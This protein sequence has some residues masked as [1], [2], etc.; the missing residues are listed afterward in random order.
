MIT[1]TIFFHNCAL[2]KTGASAP[3]QSLHRRATRCV[4]E[5]I[6]VAS[7]HSQR[8]WRRTE[9]LSEVADGERRVGAGKRSAQSPFELRIKISR[10]VVAR[11]RCAAG[12]AAAVLT[13]LA[14]GFATMRGTGRT[15]LES[16]GMKEYNLAQAK[17]LLATDEVEVRNSERRL[18]LMKRKLAGSQNESKQGAERSK[19]LAK[20][21]KSKA[22]NFELQAD[23]SA[24]NLAK[25]RLSGDKVPAATQEEAIVEENDDKLF[26]RALRR[27]AL[28][29]SRA[30][31]YLDHA[32]L[33]LEQ[34][35][36]SA[37]LKLGELREERSLAT[38][39]QRM[40][41]DRKNV[42]LLLSA[43]DMKPNTKVDAE[44]EEAMA[45]EKLGKGR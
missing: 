44:E 4:G 1:L 31:T 8:V 15:A 30:G 18:S 10:G 39:K 13:V 28:R 2:S 41:T 35:T 40:K 9:G 33:F 3:V 27:A 22:E 6:A 12:A 14:A 21:L 36:S 43:K 20:K 45:I 5:E 23:L 24:A 34:Y 37:A 29:S 19:L 38:A 26:A 7:A 11:R 17:A 16:E 42:E 32:H 25:E